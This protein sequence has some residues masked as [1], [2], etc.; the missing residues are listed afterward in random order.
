MHNRRRARLA[1]AAGSFTYAE[2]LALT[3]SYRERC[4]YC[5]G[6]GPPQV[7]HR[8]PLSLGGTNSIDN[9]LPACRRCNARKHT[10]TD[11]E[12]RARLAAE[13]RG[14]RWLREAPLEWSYDAAG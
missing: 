9:I 11:E 3:L 7:E 6:G 13:A 5:G 12:F 1:D 10:L 8:V 14:E 2:W 4:A